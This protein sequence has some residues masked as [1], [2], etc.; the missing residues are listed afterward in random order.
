MNEVSR[1]SIAIISY[2]QLDII[3]AFNKIRKWMFFKLVCPVFNFMQSA[4]PDS[5]ALNHRK[6]SK[7]QEMWWARG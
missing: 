3:V 1:V 6:S 4:A 7:R 5:L 2:S